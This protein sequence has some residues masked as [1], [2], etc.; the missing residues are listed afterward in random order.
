[1]Y[2]VFT[3]SFVFVSVTD[4]VSA[5]NEE[6]DK[7]LLNFKQEKKLFKKKNEKASEE[8]QTATREGGRGLCSTTRST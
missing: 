6:I 3:H 4:R 1:M 8:N 5:A 2:F 7:N